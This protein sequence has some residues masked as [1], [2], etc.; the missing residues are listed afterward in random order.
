MKIVSYSMRSPSSRSYAFCFSINLAGEQPYS[1]A[2]IGSSNTEYPALFTRS[3][4][5]EQI[6]SRFASILE[7]ETLRMNDEGTL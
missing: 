5:R 1:R 4:I 6:S 7:E 2:P 3:L